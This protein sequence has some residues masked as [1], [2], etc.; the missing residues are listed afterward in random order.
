MRAEVGV[1]L[2][3]VFAAEEARIGGEGR[4]VGGFEDE[5]F[6]SVD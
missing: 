4:R 5:M 2:G 6:V 1:G 3:E